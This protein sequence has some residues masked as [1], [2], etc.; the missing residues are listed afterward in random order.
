MDGG[1]TRPEALVPTRE[2]DR[3]DRLVDGL[4][5]RLVGGRV[6]IL[7]VGLTEALD[8]GRKWAALDDG[9]IPMLVEGR[10]G[11]R[12]GVLEED[13]TEDEDGRAPKLDFG[14]VVCRDGGR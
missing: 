12:V 5:D 7:V 4:V 2:P 3:T 10:G 1:R 11:A 9:R 14:R 8:A 6:D 13:W